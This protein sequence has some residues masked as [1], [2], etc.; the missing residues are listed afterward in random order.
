MIEL[1]MLV[2]GGLRY[3]GSGCS[4]DLIEEAT[5]VSDSIRRKFIKY[6]FSVWEQKFCNEIVSLPESNDDLHCIGGLYKILGVP[7]Y[8]GSTSCVHIVWNKH[9]A[10]LLA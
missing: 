1:N 8:I 9:P 5:N 7:G 2:L 4:F 10:E 6:R 3:I